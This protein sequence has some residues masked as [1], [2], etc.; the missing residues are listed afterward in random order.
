MGHRARRGGQHVAGA[1]IELGHRL[2][3]NPKLRRLAA[4]VGRMREQA[5]A[6]R[7]TLFERASEEVFAVG[8]A[9][10]S[11]ACCRPSC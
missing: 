1:Q 3:S 2:A 8:R 10:T 11:T 6:L 5:L 4:L 7:R 9:A